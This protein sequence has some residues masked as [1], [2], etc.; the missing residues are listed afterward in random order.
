MSRNELIEDR[1]SDVCMDQGPPNDP[2]RVPL[3]LVTRARAKLFME[4]LQGLVRMVQDQH[5]VHRDI[6]GQEG[7]KQI[8]YTMIQ[9]YG[10]SSGPPSDW[11]V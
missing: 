3:G 7:Y 6:E 10:E 8:I 4:S 11:A 2:V 1:I 5:G 9:A